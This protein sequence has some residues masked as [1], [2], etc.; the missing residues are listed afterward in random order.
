MN[1]KTTIDA[2]LNPCSA[3]I[4][5]KTYGWPYLNVC[6]WGKRL[7]RFTVGRLT[8]DIHGGGRRTFT[9][10]GGGANGTARYWNLFWPL[11]SVMWITRKSLNAPD[12][13]P[14]AAK[15]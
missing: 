3:E 10:M 7:I 9:C 8:M 2:I 4:D 13:R 1:G 6:F 11:G 12:Q 5:R 14:E 15:V